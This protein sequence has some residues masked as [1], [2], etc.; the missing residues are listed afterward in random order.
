MELVKDLLSG[1]EAK[2]L[3]MSG[4][5]SRL[6]ITTVSF[7]N[8]V[9]L[10]HILCDVEADPDRGHGDLS[11]NNNAVPPILSEPGSAVAEGVHPIWIRNFGTADAVSS[12]RTLPRCFKGQQFRPAFLQISPNNR[13]PAIV[14]LKS[15]LTR[16]A[17]F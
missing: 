4:R 3:S 1:R 6:R 11:L 15:S 17:Q 10:K 5:R 9:N 2:N 8:T 12:V 7:V 14:D 16:R 13:I